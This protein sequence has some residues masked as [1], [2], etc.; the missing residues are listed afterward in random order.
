MLDMATSV[1]A[2]GRLSEST[3]RGE[4]IPAEWVTSTGVLKPMGGA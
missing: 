4:Q 2:A 1:V 3:D